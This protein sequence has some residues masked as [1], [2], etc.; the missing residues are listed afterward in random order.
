MARSPPFGQ[1]G[2]A[3]WRTLKVVRSSSSMRGNKSGPAEASTFRPAARLPAPSPSG[4]VLAGRCSA[5]STDRAQA[6]ARRCSLAPRAAPSRCRSPLA[7]SC[8]PCSWRRSSASSSARCCFSG[9]LAGADPTSGQLAGS[10]GFGSAVVQIIPQGPNQ[11]FALFE[12]GQFAIPEP[13]T[14]ALPGLGLAGLAAGRR[15]K[16]PSARGA[17]QPRSFGGLLLCAIGQ[18]ESVSASAA[19]SRSDLRPAARPLSRAGS[20]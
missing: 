13:G 9:S 12:I 8:K 7:C 2:S 1:D 14:F 17:R 5:S 6:I 16:Q 15:R 19:S 10:H 3:G 4:R 20:C 18:V 11:P